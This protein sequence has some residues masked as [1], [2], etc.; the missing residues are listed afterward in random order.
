MRKLTANELKR[1]RLYDTIANAE[2]ENYNVKGH[3]KQ[4]M[5]LEDKEDGS[6]IVVKAILKKSKVDFE[7]EQIE[8]P[9]EQVKDEK[10]D[11]KE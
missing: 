6:H 5:L 8:R 10:E 1:N 3:V 2:F 9:T 11:T 4:G 7:K